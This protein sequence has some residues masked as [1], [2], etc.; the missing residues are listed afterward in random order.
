MEAVAGDRL[1][2]DEVD[3]TPASSD[4]SDEELKLSKLEVLFSLGVVASS[5][6]CK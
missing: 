6:G 1:S 2:D 5:C 3:L 4:G